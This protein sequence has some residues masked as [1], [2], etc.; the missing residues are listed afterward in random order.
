MGKKLTK[1]GKKCRK[2]VKKKIVEKLSEKVK[3]KIWKVGENE[4]QIEKKTLKIDQK[5][6]KS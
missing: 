5:S 3:Q 1:T 4:S 2:L 6:K